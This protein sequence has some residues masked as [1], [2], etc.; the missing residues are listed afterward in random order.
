MNYV[1]LRWSY[2]TTYDRPQAD[3]ARLWTQ[4][5]G[6]KLVQRMVMVVEGN[7]IRLERQCE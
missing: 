1:C 3:S 7:E 5:G 6:L 2:W 4:Y